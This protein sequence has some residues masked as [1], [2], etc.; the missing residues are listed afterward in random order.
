[1]S[2]RTSVADAREH[3]LRLSDGRRLH[4][5]EAGDPGGDL[6]VI[7]HGTPGSGILARWW[8]DDAA[9]RGLRLVGYDRPGYGRSDRQP[10]RSVADAAADTAAIADHLSTE[11]FLTWGAS[12]GG[13][14]A[15]A[16]ASL[17]PN[18]VI[19]AAALA[20]VAP[21]RAVGLDWLAGMG[22]DNVDEFAAAVAGVRVLGPHLA[23]A[24][25]GL[26]TAGA[27]ALAEQLR[28][29]LSAPDLAVLSGDLVEFLYAW[30]L[31][32]QRL[33]HTG[34]LDD[35]LAFVRDWGFDIASITI[36]ILVVQGRHDRMV[37]FGHG[38]W[39][40]EHIPKATARLSDIDGHLTLVTAIGPLHAWLRAAA[41]DLA[42]LG[43]RPRG[44]AA[45]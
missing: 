8:A 34:W 15:L 1:M 10:G 35:D 31:H 30:L 9:A 25:D 45:G 24:R 5:F 32:G 43:A 11:R 28:S 3:D 39:L 7:H 36:P 12:G 38:V 21:Y 42:E 4:V 20:S 29:L 44:A 37:P 19:A 33:G 40:A 27:A 14:H 16:C 22:Q 17:L 6:V 23:R 2:A 26:L 13:P 18:R 41:E